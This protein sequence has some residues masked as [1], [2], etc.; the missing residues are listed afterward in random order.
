MSCIV[1]NL[2]EYSGIADE[3]PKCP[4]AFTEI[5]VEENISIP[6]MKPDMEQIIKIISEVNILHKQLVKTPIGE[7]VSGII[8]TGR[9]LIIEA[10]IRQKILY[11]ADEPSQTVH[12]TEYEK[13]FSSFIILPPVCRHHSK[14]M[15]ES[16]SVDPY[17]EDIYAKLV[18]NRTIFNNTT[19]F[20]DARSPLFNK[21]RFDVC[22]RDSY[23]LHYNKKRNR[24]NGSLD[25]KELDF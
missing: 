12:A 21:R 19:I 4:K 13:V 23:Y 6:E 22:S 24:I 1:K 20:F 11:V 10:V 18:N 5:S 14:N 2:I 8:S 15:F 25:A 16:I 17:I 3:Y 7:S 9:K